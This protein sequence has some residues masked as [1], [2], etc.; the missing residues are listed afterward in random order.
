MLQRTA[1]K[2]VEKEYWPTH[3][4]KDA[5]LMVKLTLS[6]LIN[7]VFV[8]VIAN[9]QLEDWY[10]QNGLVSYIALVA[11]GTS[12]VPHV[13]TAI[14][15]NL[16]I[17]KA[18]LN[19]RLNGFDPNNPKGALATQ[20]KLNKAFENP[21]LDLP[22][23]YSTVIKIFIIGLN[24]M[25][26]VP[27]ITIAITV[28]LAFAY[29]ADKYALL[30]RCSRPYTQSM[31]MPR[32]AVNLLMYAVLVHAASICWFLTPCLEAAA[33]PVAMVLAAS[34]G[35]VGFII[36]ILPA[37]MKR[38]LFCC[39]SPTWKDEDHSEDLIYYD[40]QNIFTADEKYHMAHPVYKMIM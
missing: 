17:H 13:M 36:L 37:S 39:C 29:F 33:K 2:L 19:R 14:G 7:T 27:L 26:L 11:L 34:C 1:K 24:F 30:Y 22:K 31:L 3:T 35:V 12:F 4:E 20:D 25:A 28:A 5:S 10:R 8:I 23:R 15:L 9:I 16:L 18:L 6:Q 38:C 21:S 32:T 40:A